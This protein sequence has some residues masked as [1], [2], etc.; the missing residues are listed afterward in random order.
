MHGGRE[1]NLMQ[2]R[3]QGAEKSYDSALMSLRLRTLVIGSLAAAVAL[4]STAA[5][6][7]SALHEAVAPGSWKLEAGESLGRGQALVSANGRTKF[8]FDDDGNLVL[9]EDGMMEWSSGTGG[10]GADRLIMQPDGD[11]VM[12]R[13]HPS[14][15]EPI[16]SSESGGFPG[17]VLS[18]G[19][20]GGVVI[21]RVDTPILWSVAVPAPDVGLTG[22]QHIVYGRGD[23]MVWLVAADGTLFDS[24]SVSGRATSP[25]PGRYKVF[26]KSRYTQ[27]RTGTVLMEYMVRFVKRLPA[28]SIGFHT[29]PTTRSGRPVQTEEELGRFRSAGCVRQSNDKA[30]QLYH[31]TP[32]GTPVIVLA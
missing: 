5:P 8:L 1:K 16:W 27:S 15:D 6:A 29:I 23:Q 10:V 28:R 4:V 14:G 22:V 18:V 20:D 30:E 31:W 7:A 25:V 17:A 11:L 9:Y 12:Y 3:S 21:R 2:G 32:V 26:S 24:Y 13:S 19:D